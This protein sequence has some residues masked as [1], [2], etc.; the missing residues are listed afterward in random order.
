MRSLTVKNFQS[1]KETNLAFVPGINVIIGTSDSG[2]TA[3]F[4]ALRWLIW[5]RPSGEAFRSSWGGDTEVKLETN[6]GTVQRIRTDK[7]NKYCLKSQKYKAIKSD[8][9]EEIQSLLN[10]DRINF[11]QQLERP[12]LLDSS[13]GEV[14]KHFNK[15][16]KIDLIDTSIQHVEKWIHG[17]QQDIKTAEQQKKELEQS[18]SEYAYLDDVEPKIQNLEQIEVEYNSIVKQE[19]SLNTLY[20]ELQSLENKIALKQPILNLEGN[21]N[22][23]IKQVKE[24]D[25]LKS[26]EKQLTTLLDYI[27]QTTKKMHLLEKKVRAEAA[28]E[29]LLGQIKQK[30]DKEKQRSLLDKNIQSI[31]KMEDKILRFTFSIEEKSSIF[32][33]NMPSTC[34]LCGQKV[35]S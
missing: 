16:A 14:A 18:L 34:P 8:V 19:K 10:I 6:E 7:D 21:V 28:I 15:T 35:A 13:P 9:P 20:Q 33:D 31:S 2:K 11:Q 5:N 32:H 1:H 3:I 4:R 25:E 30:R 12:F 23:Q 29:K 22:N 24:R 27:E 26:K 17:L